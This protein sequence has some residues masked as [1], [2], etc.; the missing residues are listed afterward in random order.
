MMLSATLSVAFTV[1][2][3]VA[4][5]YLAGQSAP[6]PSGS[7]APGPAAPTATDARDI[8][9]APAAGPAA[10]PNPPAAPPLN[11][12][13]ERPDLGFDPPRFARLTPDRGDKPFGFLL[14]GDQHFT[15]SGDSA[16]FMRLFLKKLPTLPEF[17]FVVTLGDQINNGGNY[18][19][20]LEYGSNAASKEWFDTLRKM[21]K[22][23]FPLAGNHEPGSRLP[24]AAERAL[25]ADDKEV[26]RLIAAATP[27]PE[28]RAARVAVYRGLRMDIRNGVLS[29]ERADWGKFFEINFYEDLFRNNRDR[30]N[31]PPDASSPDEM[32][33]SFRHNGCLFLFADGNHNTR[34]NWDLAAGRDSVGLRQVRWMEKELAAAE[35]DGLRHSF[36]MFHQPFFV[37]DS[38]HEPDTRDMRT[39]A[40]PTGRPLTPEEQAEQRVRDILGAFRARRNPLDLPPPPDRELVH[41]GELFRRYRVTAVFNGHI[42][43]YERFLWDLGGGKRLPMITTGGSGASRGRSGLNPDPEIL[44]VDHIQRSLKGTNPR[45]DV[46]TAWPGQ[47][48]HQMYPLTNSQQGELAERKFF[49][50]HVRVVG[51]KASLRLIPL[52]EL[53]RDGKAVDAYET[54]DD[55]SAEPTPIPEPPTPTNF[56]KHVLADG[57][58]PL[59]AVVGDFRGP[60]KRE[61]LAVDLAR[62]VWIAPWDHP[63]QRTRIA[64]VESPSALVVH[65]LDGNGRPDLFVGQFGRAGGRGAWYWLRNP[66]PAGGEWKSTVIDDGPYA[67]GAQAAVFADVTGDGHRELVVGCFHSGVVSYYPIPRDPTVPRQWKRHEIHA[68]YGSEL[69]DLPAPGKTKDARDAKD[70]KEAKHPRDLV[71]YGLKALAAAPLTHPEKAGLPAKP[72]EKAECVFAAY[73]RANESLVMFEAVPPKNGRDDDHRDG[74]PLA[75]IDPDRCTWKRTVIEGGPGDFTG[76]LAVDINNDGRT[77]LVAIDRGGTPG[78]TRGLIAYIQGVGGDGKVTWTKTVID[79]D[80]FGSGTPAAADID[81]DGR[82]DLLIIHRD[83]RTHIHMVLLYANKGGA[84]FQR[85]LVGHI[86]EEGPLPGEAGRLIVA[87]LN[88]DGRPDVLAAGLVTGRL[89]WFETLPPGIP[90]DPE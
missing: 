2:L 44:T 87:D 11:P 56:R 66:G 72:R 19:D 84:V 10:A 57:G 23:I 49:V 62:G 27:D 20:W 21:G 12:S 51:G 7:A 15:G 46:L 61:I 88:G 3:L 41:F 35:R 37:S 86:G 9:S 8:P 26:E 55:L 59:Q 22:P 60:G 50:V 73:S 69:P 90:G 52:E 28:L 17:D 77:D 34:K 68:P 76:V 43:R 5:G 82:L 25:L 36:V 65:D 80:P 42:H 63:E 16:K 31:H 75:P 48:V 78:S 4:A 32:W 67:R 18:R 58:F 14:M 30:I 89:V 6:S 33:Y 74:D 24:S 53:K 85:R 79:R 1:P 45:K 13:T 64:Q 81:G 70:P 83:E 71:G 39:V 40:Y 54:V 47:R 29:R 38:V